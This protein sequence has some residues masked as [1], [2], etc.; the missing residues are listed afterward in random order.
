LTSSSH[1]SQSRYPE[2]RH[3]RNQTPD[4]EQV[5]PPILATHLAV[6]IK[7]L[8][9]SPQQPESRDER[10]QQSSQQIRSRKI[11]RPK[12]SAANSPT[13]ITV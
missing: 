13:T 7:D 5:E 9:H 6:V 2:N 3:Q 4:I 1:A 11:R 8:E 10:A 12:H